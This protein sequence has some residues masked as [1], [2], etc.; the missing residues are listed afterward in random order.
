MG[1]SVVGFNEEAMDIVCFICVEKQQPDGTSL[2]VPHATAFLTVI[3]GS[4]HWT[5]YVVTAKHNLEAA[6]NQPLYLRFNS[7]ARLPDVETYRDEWFRHDDADVAIIRI[8]WRSGAHRLQQVAPEQFIGADYQLRVLDMRN[9]GIIQLPGVFSVSNMQIQT[10]NDV[11]I[12]GLFA[13]HYGRSKNLSSC[14]SWNN[15]THAFR[16]HRV[17]ASDGTY[18]MAP[19]YLVEFRSWGGTS[20]SPVLVHRQLFNLV[21]MQ[22]TALPGDPNTGATES[23]TVSFLN[24]E[25]EVLGLFGIWGTSILNSKHGRARKNPERSPLPS[26][27]ALL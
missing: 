14:P 11:S 13:Q 4:P 16:A 1:G 12:I 19:G 10:G 20:G 15:R 17:Q 9:A 23:E 2:R 18:N 6:G 25:V 5:G 22:V 24:P 8:Q 21:R 26:I 3:K 27:L 7:E